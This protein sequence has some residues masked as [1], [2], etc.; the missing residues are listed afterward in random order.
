ML[1]LS[2]PA[3]AQFLQ[4]D[5]F[6]EGIWPSI[7]CSNRNSN[8]QPGVIR[9]RGWEPPRFIDDVP[10][11]AP[12]LVLRHL[13]I[14]PLRHSKLSD[15]DLVELA[16]EHAVREGL[17]TL[18]DL[19][20]AG[21]KGRGEA[22]LREVLARRPKDEPP[23]ESYAETRA[24]QVFRDLG[25][26]PWRQV[27]IFERGRQKHRVDFVIPFRRSRKRPEI[28][29]PPDGLLVEVDSAEWHEGSFEKDHERQST[30]DRLGFHWITLTPKQVEGG[31]MKRSIDGAMRRATGSPV[32]T[33]RQPMRP[34]SPK[35]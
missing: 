8:P 2:G 24:V 14:E 4:L 23:T 21:A 3:A 12:S 16:L 13:A 35:R 9:S 11:A 7:W 25:I 33:K 30:Y 26:T 20:T 1:A 31:G 6:R 17:V 27:A 34:R 22:V 5:G 28:L 29:A 15:H 18:G 19:K 32:E 10:I